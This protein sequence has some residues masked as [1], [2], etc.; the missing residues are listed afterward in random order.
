MLSGKREL[1]IGMSP[2]DGFAVP[3]IA[4][5]VLGYVKFKKS[6]PHSLPRPAPASSLTIR[7]W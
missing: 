2:G 5:L 4:L 7:I 1:G 6:P 3:Q